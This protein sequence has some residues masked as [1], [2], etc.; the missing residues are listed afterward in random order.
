MGLDKK[1][2]GSLLFIYEEIRVDDIVRVGC[3]S[4][5]KRNRF[6]INCH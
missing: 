2:F 5:G 1:N 3:F 6:T 4:I